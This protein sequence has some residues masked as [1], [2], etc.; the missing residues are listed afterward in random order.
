[1][2]NIIAVASQKGGAGKTTLVMALAG[3]AMAAGQRVVV[4]D[5]DPQASVSTWSDQRPEDAAPTVASIQATRLPQELTLAHKIADLILLDT[6][7]HSEPTT[8]AVARA[9]DTVLIPCRPGF[10][11]IMAIHSTADMIA[12]AGKRPAIIFNGVRPN[13]K[14]AQDAAAAVAA[15]PADVCPAHLS[16]RSDFDAAVTHGQTVHEYA[17]SSKAACEIA[18]VA[19]WVFARLP[20]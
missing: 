19:T 6:P 4:L 2:A 7:P 3:Q 1:M 16:L 8:L 20:R 5:L 12:M 11:D 10:L 17:P 18:A 14:Q 9:A 13:S 15:L